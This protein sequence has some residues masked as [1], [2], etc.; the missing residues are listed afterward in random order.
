ML[1]PCLWLKWPCATLKMNTGQSSTEH[2]LC[3]IWIV[4]T[5]FTFDFR[6]EPV[7]MPAGSGSGPGGQ[8]PQWQQPCQSCSCHVRAT[9]PSG[10]SL[11]AGAMPQPDRILLVFHTGRQTPQWDLRP[12][13]DPQLHWSDT[14]YSEQ[15]ITGILIFEADYC[16]YFSFMWCFDESAELCR[17]YQSKIFWIWTGHLIFTRFKQWGL[18]PVWKHMHL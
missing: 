18:S 14:L 13:S 10:R 2:S 3:L 12:P 5:W 4:L 9:V 11:P 8:H 6:S 1:W 15:Q 7:Q 16:R 17:T